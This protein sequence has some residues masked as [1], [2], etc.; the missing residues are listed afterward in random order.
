[1][2]D[3]V[4]DQARRILAVLPADRAAWPPVRWLIRTAVFDRLRRQ[5]EADFVLITDVAQ[6]EPKLL[7]LPYDFGNP[8]NGAEIAL[9]I[10]PDACVT[11]G[12]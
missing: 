2:T 4:I 3:P 7:G 5:I 1:M 8:A 11:A 6:G 10:A 12:V 9:T